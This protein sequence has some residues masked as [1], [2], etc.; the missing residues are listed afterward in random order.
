M[1]KLKAWQ[2]GLVFIVGGFVFTRLLPP[3]DDNIAFGAGAL[4]GL[5]GMVLVAGG[6]LLVLVSVVTTLSKAAKNRSK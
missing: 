5:I 2:C 1:I 6:V 4:R 3:E